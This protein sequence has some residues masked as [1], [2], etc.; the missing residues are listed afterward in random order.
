MK[1]LTNI[2][3]RGI[4]KK[5]NLNKIQLIIKNISTTYE[6]GVKST[7][8][9]TRLKFFFNARYKQNNGLKMCSNNLE[10]ISIYHE[11][12]V[13]ELC[14]LHALNN[15]FQDKNAF[16]KCELDSICYNLSPE[17]WINPH[18]SM[19]GLGNYDVNVIISA[20]QSRGCGMV[21]FDK[22]KDPSCLNLNNIIGLILNIPSD[23][24]LSFL[25]I[26]KRRHWIALKKLNGQFYNLDSK[27]TQPLLIGIQELECQDKEIFIVITADVEKS[28]SWL[29][30]KSDYNNKII[31]STN[32]DAEEVLISDIQLLSEEG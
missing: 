29:K 24:K 7:S 16:L 11:K 26:L 23:Y 27:L 21:W 8:K 18:K 15:L 17:H 25:T 30:E 32:R 20:L 22:R 31:D 6:R 9:P 14:A 19:L 4:F 2:Q 10:T 1:T 3:V 28:G 13:R 5:T 12:Q